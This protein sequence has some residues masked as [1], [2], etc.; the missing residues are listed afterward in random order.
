MWGKTGLYGGWGDGELRYMDGAKEFQPSDAEVKKPCPES[1]SPLIS[2]R[3][4]S[5]GGYQRGGRPCAVAAGT[6]QFR[7]LRAM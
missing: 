2:L 6:E 1:A 7:A 3:R 5:P 4:L